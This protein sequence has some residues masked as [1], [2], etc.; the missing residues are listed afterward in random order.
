MDGQQ[1]ANHEP[2]G[3]QHAAPLEVLDADGKPAIL[4]VPFPGRVV[5]SHIWRVNVGRMCLYLM[6]T[7]F[8]MN[9]EFDRQITHQLLRRRPGEPYR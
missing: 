1:I 4:E 2:S 7:D 5:Y 3:F 6:D 9:S 8:D